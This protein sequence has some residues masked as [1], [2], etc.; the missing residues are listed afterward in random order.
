VNFSIFV[1]FGQIIEAVKVNDYRAAACGVGRLITGVTCATQAE[2]L[3]NA[4]PKLAAAD[5]TDADVD[6][7]PATPAELYSHAE[8]FAAELESLSHKNDHVVRMGDASDAELTPGQWITLVT[9]VVGILR[10]FIKKPQDWQPTPF[11]APPVSVST[12]VS[13]KPAEP[14]LPPMS[15]PGSPKPSPKPAEVDH[16]AEPAGGSGKDEDDAPPAD[17]DKPSGKPEPKKK[18]K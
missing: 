2:L 16:T 14:A 17:A 12:L 8:S 6:P 18:G 11:P 9:F 10:K 4:R 1:L 7:A 15:I 13:G 5:P 3:A